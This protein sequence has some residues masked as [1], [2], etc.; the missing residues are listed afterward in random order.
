M[1][2]PKYYYSQ[3]L[4][5]LDFGKLLRYW[6]D[7]IKILSIYGNEKPGDIHNS[8]HSNLMNIAD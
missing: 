5:K 2:I 1:Y 4:V 3:I 8:E 7:V 6:L